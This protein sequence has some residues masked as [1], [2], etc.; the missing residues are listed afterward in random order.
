MFR[1]EIQAGDTTNGNPLAVTNTSAISLP[2][3]NIQVGASI[4]LSDVSVQLPYLQIDATNNN[5][6][7]VD[8]SRPYVVNVT[9]SY[10]APFGTPID[11][12]YAQTGDYVDIDV[13][14]SYPLAVVGYPY[15]VIRVD[16]Y[17][18]VGVNPYEHHYLRN[19][20]F[21]RLS[22]NVITFRYE[23]TPSDEA[24]KLDVY[25]FDSLKL[26]G[27]NIFSDTD[28]LVV[29]A[30]PDINAF[31]IPSS[32]KDINVP[33]PL[34]K[35]DKTLTGTLYLLANSTALVCMTLAP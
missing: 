26:N 27:S 24:K 34:L 22:S 13:R 7:F 23:V 19:A 4:P 21:L 16:M 8:T 10:Q 31:S 20:T 3:A 1:Y 32:F 33:S 25:Q 12:G 14:F 29:K 6:V 35:L 11:L 15:L 18:L 30:I 5:Q 2:N 9:A 17:D 28:S